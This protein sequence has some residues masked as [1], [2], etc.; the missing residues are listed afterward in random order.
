MHMPAT[1]ES[2][3]R[4][5]AF[6]RLIGPFLVIVTGILVVRSPDLGTM[7]SAFFQNEALVWMM[8]ALLFFCGL[9]IIAFHQYWSSSAAILI[10]IFGWFLAIR[11][12]ILLAAPQLI[13]RGGIASMHMVPAVRIGFSLLVLIGLW[14]TYVGWFTK[15]LEFVKEIDRI[16]T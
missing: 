2:K 11:G 4:T 3:A 1:L 13:L 8:G 6:A 16:E 10:S 9:L 7:L 12:V 5:R 14:L 15:P